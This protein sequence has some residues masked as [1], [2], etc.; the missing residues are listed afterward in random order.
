[1]TKYIVT[2]T[3]PWSPSKFQTRISGNKLYDTKK[4]AYN[5]IRQ[6]V[7]EEFDEEELPVVCSFYY[8]PPYKRFVY[9]LDGKV[10][11]IYRICPVQFD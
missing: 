3:Y 8:E 5:E 2:E 1:M 4:E 11:V 7:R 9:E 10:E 6:L